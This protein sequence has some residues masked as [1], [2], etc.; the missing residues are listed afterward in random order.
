MSF[1]VIVAC[2]VLFPVKGL[3]GAALPP[4]RF[5]C[6]RM[7]VEGGSTLFAEAFCVYTWKGK[8]DLKQLYRQIYRKHM[9]T[10]VLTEN[11]C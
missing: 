10:V 9:T 7:E 4:Q 1:R 8:E 6:K 5:L 3:T 2:S 11:I